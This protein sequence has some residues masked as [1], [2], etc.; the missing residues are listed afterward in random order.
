V[1]RFVNP[2][3]FLG[4]GELMPSFSMEPMNLIVTMSNGDWS[5]HVLKEFVKVAIVFYNRSF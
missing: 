2:F 3:Q 1:E 5:C 4:F